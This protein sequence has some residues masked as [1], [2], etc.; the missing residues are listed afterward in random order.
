MPVLTVKVRQ[1]QANTGIIR[2]KFARP[3]LSSEK[4]DVALF[5]HF[6]QILSHILLT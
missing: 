4:L 1:L 2:E 6:S 3:E 5:L